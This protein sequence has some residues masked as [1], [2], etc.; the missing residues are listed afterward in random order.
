MRKIEL[1]GEDVLDTE[2]SPFESLNML[3]HRTWLQENIHNL[4]EEELEL[5][6]LNDQKL[7]SNASNM[8][9]HIKRIYDFSCSKEPLEQWWWHLNKIVD[10][11]LNP[12]KETEK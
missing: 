7:F 9:Q 6:R 3:H 5:L 1:Y 4:T 10:G 2:L 11:S 12:Y 8:F